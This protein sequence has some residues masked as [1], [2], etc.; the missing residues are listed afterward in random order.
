MYRNGRT[1]L[2]SYQKNRFLK[3]I[4]HKDHVSVEH[5]VIR[6]HGIVTPDALK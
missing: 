6:D 2:G 4:F 5:R 1:P 3:I